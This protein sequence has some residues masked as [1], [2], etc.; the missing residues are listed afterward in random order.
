ME[1]PVF[2]PCKHHACKDCLIDFFGTL[3]EKGEEPHCPVCKAGPY[4]DSQVDRILNSA[5]GGDE[6]ERRGSERPKGKGYSVVTSSPASG[7][8]VLTID[9]SE[10][11]EERPRAK[12]VRKQA[13]MD[14][15]SSDEDDEAVVRPAGEV[16]E[17]VKALEARK[18]VATKVV[19]PEKEDD[20]DEEDDKAASAKVDDKDEDFKMGDINDSDSD[21]DAVVGDAKPRTRAIILDK[22]F[23]SSTK[24]AALVASLK[25]ARE[26]DPKLKAVVFSR[27]SC[28]SP[29]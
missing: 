20:D 26:E 11:E 16:E 23:K 27:T 15:S 12:K 17:R 24:L 18:A 3:E 2:L 7:G 14:V 22:D 6:E 21:D 5:G 8:D 25:K 28:T 9:S 29:V 10:E 4:T 1:T 13:K 19:E